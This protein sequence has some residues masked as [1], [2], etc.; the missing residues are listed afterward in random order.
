[1]PHSLFVRMGLGVSDAEWPTG[2]GLRRS[3][4]PHLPVLHVEFLTLIN[5]SPHPLYVFIIPN[6]SNAALS[7]NTK[8]LSLA[9]RCQ[10]AEEAE[11][12][13]KCRFVNVKLRSPRACFAPEV[14]DF[15]ALILLWASGADVTR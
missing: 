13:G 7:A 11:Q 14:F 3:W 5:L 10:E 6:S 15:D 12:C 9:H 1:M 4:M 2:N 8:M